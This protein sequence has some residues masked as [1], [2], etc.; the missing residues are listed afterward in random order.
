MLDHVNAPPDIET[1]TAAY[2][3]RFSGP[4]GDFL[5]DGQDQGVRLLLSG[6]PLEGAQVLDVGGGHAQ[7]TPLL[8]GLGV[9][10]WVQG[11]APSCAER[12][13]RWSDGAE[14]RLHFVT[15]SLLDLPFADRAFDL[16]IGIRLLAHVQR[17][18]A[19]L[20]EMSRV[21][22]R[23]LLVEYPPIKSANALA[24]L[25]F[26]VKRFVEHDTRHFACFSM[27]Q[28][29]PVIR[30]L[31]FSDITQYNQFL[32]PMVLHRALRRP[33]LSQRIEAW[34]HRLGLTRAL[35]GPALLLAKRPSERSATRASSQPP[36]P[37]CARS[38]DLE[39]GN[40]RPLYGTVAPSDRASVRGREYVDQ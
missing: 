27:R 16:V 22:R 36:S 34:G 14:G 19:L 5:L 40:D 7:L 8:L 2:A 35:G 9:D 26:T 18:E 33:D 20:A 21:C 24:P 32:M 15:S 25:L 10:V 13:A 12:L 31:G 6:L 1:A 4:I 3:G 39:Q 37:R 23:Y 30:D 11:S 38:V 29:A 17:W 28:L